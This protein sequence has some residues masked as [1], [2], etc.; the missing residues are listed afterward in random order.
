MYLWYIQKT[1]QIIYKLKLSLKLY[2]IS[3]YKEIESNKA[4]DKIINIIY[5]LILLSKQ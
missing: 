1:K 5:N 4:I 2:Q 3:G